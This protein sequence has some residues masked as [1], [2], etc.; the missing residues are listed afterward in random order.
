[1]LIYWVSANKVRGQERYQEISRRK[2][3][4]PLILPGR[5]VGRG[6]PA[7][8]HPESG[9]QAPSLGETGSVTHPS[10]WTTKAPP[11]QAPHPR[12]G[13][14]TAAPYRLRLPQGVPSSFLLPEGLV[15]DR[16]YAP[17][18]LCPLAIDHEELLFAGGKG[19]F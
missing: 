8:G 10:S 17:Q 19:N 12:W 1:M 9:G 6:T 7:P 18:A 11:G 5:G 14:P 4:H 13:P 3:R 15:C 16:V 2:W